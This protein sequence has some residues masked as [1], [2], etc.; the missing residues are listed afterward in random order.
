MIRRSLRAFFR[1]AFSSPRLLRRLFCRLYRCPT[2]LRRNTDRPSTGSTHLTFLR[3]CS[4]SLRR[5]GTLSQFAVSCPLRC[6]HFST[7]GGTELL[8]RSPSRIRGGS[9]AV[10][11]AMQQASE[12]GNLRVYLCL[13]RF[14]PLDCRLYYLWCE[15]LLHVLNLRFI[16]FVCQVCFFYLL[17]DALS[18]TS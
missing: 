8:S 9:F 10:T 16:T 5:L 7:S 11:A 15:L 17:R 14:V 2:L 13:L 6:R 18:C 12:F 3:L 1:P 4:F